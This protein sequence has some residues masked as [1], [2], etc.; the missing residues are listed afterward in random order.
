[1]ERPTAMED[2]W[3]R[4]INEKDEQ[5]AEEILTAH[6]P[7]VDY[8]VQRIGATLPTNVDREDLRSQGLV[9]LYDALL[10][11][12]HRR[13]L[14]FYTYASF[15]VRGA[16]I[17]SLRKEDWLP[18]S[19]REKAK[20]IED[21]T[22]K[23]EQQKGRYVTEHEVAD[24]LQLSIE[25]VLKTT[26]ENYMA[27]LLSIDQA[28]EDE[29]REDTH[30]LMVQDPQTPT[31]HEEAEK[32]ETKKQLQH[33]IS[34]LPE[35]EKLVLSLF[36]H[37]DLTLTEIGHILRLSTSRISQ[38]HARALFRLKQAFQKEEAKI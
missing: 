19:S 33:L 25:D 34:T 14:K 8:H 13:D 9:G 31:P 6:A 38:L 26:A 35:K 37:E 15:R 11:F 27:Q 20:M 1:M 17:D 18:R 16:I 30:P 10:K 29:N 21:T 7:L 3:A 2:H 24:T 23:L 36:Y 22:E 4:W 5:A 32:N 28:P 12:D